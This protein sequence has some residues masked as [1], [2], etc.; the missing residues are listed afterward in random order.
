MK[1]LGYYNGKYD[2]IEN[3]TIPMNDRACYFGDGVYDAAFSRNNVIFA[4]DEHIDRFFNSAGLL[5]IKIPYTK[6]EL[7]TLLIDMV[8]KVDAVE[9]FVYWQVTRGTAMRDHVFPGDDVKANIWITLEPWN[10]EYKQQ[11]LKLITLEDTRFLHCNIKTLNLL[12]NVMAAQKAKESNCQ[13]TVFHRGDRV[14]ECAHS[15]VSIIKDGIFK[16]APT[17]NLIL[18][19]IARA[20]IIKMCKRFGI[21]V[22]ET[23]FVLRELMDAD[24]VIVTSSGDFCMTACEIDGKPVGGKAPEIVEKLQNALVDEFL[25]ETK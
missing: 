1:T 20:H 6:D 18:P 14:T 21:P 17:D 8:K 4:L 22:D 12:P 25:E 19:G 15:N 9:Q 7:K 24:E 2:L 3:M 13:E 5:R 11:K 16:T 23:P 10:I